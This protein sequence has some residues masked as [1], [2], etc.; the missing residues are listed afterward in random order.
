MEPAEERKAA[1][2]TQ[3]VPD[4]NL[5]FGLLE[6]FLT[7]TGVWG[8]SMPPASGSHQVIVCGG[9]E[10]FILDVGQ[11]P[12]KKLW[13]WKAAERPEL[14]VNLRDKFETTS[15][16]KPVDGG[17]RVLI[18]SS[19]NGVA[20]VE[21][22]S[23]RVVFHATAPNAHSAAMLPGGT[24]VVA[25]SI[26]PDEPGDRLI[27]FDLRKP[28]QPLFHTAFASAHGLVWDDGRSLLWAIGGEY[29]RSYRLLGSGTGEPRLE[30]TAEYH[31]PDSDAH[32]LTPVPASDL[33]AFT[34]LHH[35]WGFD[36]SQHSFSLHP[37]LGNMGD[38]KSVS[39]HPVTKQLV[40]TQAG[41]GVWWTDTLRFAN[42]EEQVTLKGERLYKVRW[43]AAAT[44]DVGLS[45]KPVRNG[46]K[47]K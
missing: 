17:R 29:L 32:D 25:S 12:P 6:T 11:Q 3:G 35:V 38:V 10:V 1:H 20:L 21:R 43:W 44:S 30:L 9:T 42:P 19:G 28:G 37:Q 39:T 41:S 16:C 14:P 24:L 45:S 5:V 4:M 47:T 18:V 40:F 27:L 23:G 7:A 31:L 13:S 2:C 8:A 34:T 46:P 22:A 33:L 26:A 15:D 36:R